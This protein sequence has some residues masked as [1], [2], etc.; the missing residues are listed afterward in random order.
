VVGDG[1]R[2]N[3]RVADDHRSGP[4]GD[5]RISSETRPCVR[6]MRDGDALLDLA[7]RQN[8][9]GAVV[10]LNVGQRRRI[11]RRDAA[12]QPLCKREGGHRAAENQSKSSPF[13][14]GY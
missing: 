14:H 1:A 6:K 3:V 10:A 12:E 9:L 7:P 13:I 8:D 11:R 5:R 2:D 4:A